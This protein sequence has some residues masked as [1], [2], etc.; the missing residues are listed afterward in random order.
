MFSL[1]F[2]FLSK[3]FLSSLLLSLTMIFGGF[4]CSFSS[5]VLLSARKHVNFGFVLISLAWMIFSTIFVVFSPFVY[6]TLI[7]AISR[8]GFGVFG[9]ACGL[10][11]GCWCV[12]VDLG[13]RGVP[14]APNSFCFVCLCSLLLVCNRSI[15]VLIRWILFASCLI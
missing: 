6:G 11:G 9:F 1:I 5:L 4:S 2:V 13:Y 7:M 12:V 3:E 8:K 15:L 14:Q 10:V